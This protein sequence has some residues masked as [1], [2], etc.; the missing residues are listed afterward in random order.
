MVRF[1]VD[2]VRLAALI[3]SVVGLALA[4]L[5]G[6]AHAQAA[7]AA[8]PVYAET[9]SGAL[10]RYMRLLAASPKDFSALIGAGRAALALGDSQAAVGFFGRADEVSPTS[11]LPQAGMG[12]ASVADGDAAGALAYFNRAQQLGATAIVVGADRGLAFDLLGR[13]AEAQADYRAA[14]GGR[15]GDEARRRLALSLAITGN[16]DEAI[17]LLAPL[18]ARGD[19]G[20]ARCRALVLALSG[21]AAGAH[22]A[23]ESAMPGSSASMDP[24]FRKLPALRS[25]QKA[26]AVHLGIFPGAGGGP[27]SSQ[28]AYAIATATPTAPGAAA[29]PQAASGI[30]SIEEWLRSAAPQDSS[31][32]AVA[33]PVQSASVT[34]VPRPPVRVTIAAR[35]K[36]WLQLASGANA[37][38]LPSQYQRL[39]DR[40]RDILGD[41]SGF[42]AETADRARLLIGPFKSKADAETFADD[43]ASVSVSAFSWTSPAGMLI[44]KLPA[45]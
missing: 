43:L 8:P 17:A 27:A 41:I 1:P 33:P 6:Q 5:S 20:G 32:P 13:H 25:D 40:H 42:V 37:A 12:A 22:R 10:A 4:A 29:K 15:D 14:L 11:P 36:V 9:P 26:A 30:G 21:D 7:Y 39:K 28:S 35:E 18:M 24:F 16:K 34:A 31:P 2:R 23:I 38:A 19:A 3:L 45:E 44:R